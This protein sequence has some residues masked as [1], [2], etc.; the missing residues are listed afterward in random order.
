M[1]KFIVSLLIIWTKHLRQQ[2]GDVKYAGNAPTYHCIFLQ[3]R[4][5]WANAWESKPESW[6][7]VFSDPNYSMTL[8]LTLIWGPY[9][10]AEKRIMHQ[11]RRPS[12]AVSSW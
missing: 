6:L 11:W 12:F 9:Q 4:V 2:L 5:F 10:K 3:N 1:N 8:T 7:V